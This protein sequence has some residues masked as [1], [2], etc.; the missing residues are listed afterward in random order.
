LA[1]EAEQAT[2]RLAGDRGL[3]VFVVDFAGGDAGRDL[4]AQLRAAGF[5]ADRAF[6][7][8]SAKS[9]FKAADRSGARLALVVGADEA[10]AGTV[11]IKDLLAGTGPGQ[12]SVPRA[13]VVSEVRRRIGR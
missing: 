9:Q 12:V 4:T 10:A 5:R 8:R 2:A 1:V 3:D 13:D 11:G 7:D 6:D